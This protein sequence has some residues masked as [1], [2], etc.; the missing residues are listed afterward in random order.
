MYPRHMDNDIVKLLKNSGQRIDIKNGS[1]HLKILINNKLIA[2]YPFKQSRK[3]SY[4]RQDK[5][6]YS[7]IKRHLDS[8]NQ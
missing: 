6:T 5:D 1:K 2:V 8:L 3:D 7:D 4:K